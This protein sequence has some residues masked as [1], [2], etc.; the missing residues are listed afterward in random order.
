MFLSGFCLQGEFPGSDECV[1]HQESQRGKV[2][3]KVD[4]R[5]DI[6][7]RAFYADDTAMI[8]VQEKNHFHWIRGDN[9]V[10]IRLE[11]GP[12]NGGHTIE[13]DEFGMLPDGLPFLEEAAGVAAFVFDSSHAGVII[14]EPEDSEEIGA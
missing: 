8:A 14:A 9:G 3:Q 13:S 12:V 10:V 7:I 11:L 2:Q 1:E 4:G 6:S 5:G